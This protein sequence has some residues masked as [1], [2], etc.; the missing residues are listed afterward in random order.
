MASTTTSFLA[1]RH[2]VNPN[3]QGTKASAHYRLAVEGRRGGNRLAVAN[4]R[5]RLRIG[6]AL[7]PRFPKRL[8]AAQRSGRI[9]RLHH[10]RLGREAAGRVHAAG[11]GRYALEQT[12]YFSVDAGHDGWPSMVPIRSAT[13]RAAHPEQRMVP[14]GRTRTRSRC[15]ISGSIHGT[16][17]GTSAFHAIALSSVDVEFAKR[18][19]ELLLQEFY[20][21]PTGQIP[22]YEWNFSDVNPPVHAWATSSVYKMEQ[23]LH[24]V[25]DI[26]FL[27]RVFQK[28]L[29]QLHLVGEPQGSR[30]EKTSLKAAF[31][32][33]TTS[34]FSIDSAPLPEGAV[35][36]TGGRHRVDG[37]VLPEHDRDCDRVRGRKTTPTKKWS[38]KFVDHFLWISRA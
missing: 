14:H 26:E 2:A 27:E 5:A 18:Q 3:Q 31:S 1:S 32:V 9:L 28:L 15:R 7:H 33:W 20:L 34:G 6:A 19:L 17:L 25:G 30:L 37:P 13:E 29:P 4:D 10:A 11:V 16:R 12:V 23:A 38:T 35:P 8:R 21:H 22:A 36:G 24:G